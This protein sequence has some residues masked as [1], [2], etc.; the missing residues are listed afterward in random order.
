MNS[1]NL[2]L[3]RRI[4]IDIGTINR[5]YYTSRTKKPSLY[6]KISPLGNPTTSVVPQLDDW[7]YKGN[8]VSVGELQRIVRD[9]RKRSRFSQALQVSEW[10]NKNGVCI[11]SP[12]EHAVHLDLIGKVHGFVSAETYFNNLKDIDRNEKTYGALL[13]CYVL[14]RKLYLPAKLAPDAKDEKLPLIVAIDLQPMAPIEGVIQ[15]QGDITNART[16]EVNSKKIS[17]PLRI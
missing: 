5:S 16:A 12:V 17:I 7:V 10:M 1:L 14:S 9:L 2:K 11:F 8:K 13:N 6:S 4:T 15:V 3:F